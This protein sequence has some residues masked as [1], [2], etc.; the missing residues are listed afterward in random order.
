MVKSQVGAVPGRKP[1]G[2]NMRK[3]R[4]RENSNL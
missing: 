2:A 4:V 1:A 3:S